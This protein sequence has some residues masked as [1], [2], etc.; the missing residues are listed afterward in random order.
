M[1]SPQRSGYGRASADWRQR[2]LAA[3]GWHGCR[4]IGGNQNT[5]WKR[6][7]HTGNAMAPIETAQLKLTQRTPNL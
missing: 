7:P 3:V 1:G 5:G 6:S 4:R 2:S